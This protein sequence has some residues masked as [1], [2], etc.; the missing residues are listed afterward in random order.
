M[1]ADP[2][3]LQVMDRNDAKV[4]DDNDNDSDDDEMINNSS[5][6]H[7]KSTVNEELEKDENS[8]EHNTTSTSISPVDSTTVLEHNETANSSDMKTFVK[9]PDPST[10]L[11]NP[12]AKEPK[13][14][15]TTYAKEIFQQ[16]MIEFLNYAVYIIPIMFLSLFVICCLCCFIKIFARKKKKK[17]RKRSRKYSDTTSDEST[18]TETKARGKRLDNLDKKLDDIIKILNEKGNSGTV[19]R[20]DETNSAEEGEM[21][22]KKKKFLRFL[23]GK[24]KKSKKLNNAN[25]SSLDN[26]QESP[27]KAEMNSSEITDS[28]PNASD[29]DRKKEDNEAKERKELIALLKKFDQLNGESENGNNGKEKENSVIVQ[30]VTEGTDPDLEM[31]R[32]YELQRISP[33]FSNYPVKNERGWTYRNPYFNSEYPSTF[34]KFRRVGHETTRNWPNEINNEND[35][36]EDEYKD[37]P[38]PKRKV[39]NVENFKR[40]VNRKSVHLTDSGVLCRLQDDR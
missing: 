33:E 5:L 18:S 12:P 40:Y 31:N 20:S 16:Y 1:L 27:E 38:P 6:N 4:A 26:I 25:Y 15:K 29:S 14:S 23:H 32:N 13:P 22:T 17:K 28:D 39:E 3:N 2:N 30:Y 24:K 10:I 11:G 7:D 21:P 8:T 36:V 37:F 34:Q 19:W 35:L 9:K